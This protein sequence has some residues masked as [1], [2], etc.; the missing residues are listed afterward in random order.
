MKIKLFAVLTITAS[1]MF[2]SCGTGQL[3]V[4]KLKTEIDSLSYALGAARSEGF[5]QYLQFQLG[6]DSTQYNDI[7]KGLAEGYSIKTEDKKKFANLVGRQIG[8]NL[9]GMFDDLNQQIFQGDP[10][11]QLNRNSFIAGFV[12]TSF[13]KNVLMDMMEAQTYSEVKAQEIQARQMEQNY[14]EHIELNQKF[15]AENKQRSGV[16]TTASG[17]QYEVIVMGNG[18]KPTASNTV[19][20]HY[21]G[22]LIDGTEFDSSVSR[23]EPAEFGV[24]YVIQGWVEALQLMPVGS[25]FKLYIPENLAYGSG[26]SGSIQPFSTLI[27]E[28]ELL[29]IVQ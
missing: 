8:H 10:T 13:N 5:A 24:S 29:A 1:I 19:R 20:V 12:S 21:T 23:G 14:Q 28:V 27:F 3:K 11:N 16:I 15:L 2:A 17:L 18:P 4:K 25:K 6:I 7:I 22:T 9:G 26:G